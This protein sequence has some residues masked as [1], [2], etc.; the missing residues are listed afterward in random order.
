MRLMLFAVR[1]VRA[2]CYMNPFAVDSIGRAMR[3]FEDEV[4]RPAEDNPLYKHPGDF[5]LWQLGTFDTQSGEV[6]GH[7]RMQL[8]EGQ[9]CVRAVPGDKRQLPLA[10][11]N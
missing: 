7:D 1:D 10:G 8:T 4:N 11:V 2:N 3:S 9:S 6:D 5:E